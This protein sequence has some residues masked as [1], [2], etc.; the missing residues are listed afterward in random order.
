MKTITLN[1]TLLLYL[2]CLGFT[3]TVVSQTQKEAS[4]KVSSG[5]ILD[6][7]IRQ[8]NVNIATSSGTEVKVLAKNIEEDELKL[9]TMEQKS[10]KLEIKFKGEDSDE[11][12]LNLTIPSEINLDISTGGGNIS[13]KGDLKGTVDA[14]TG[15]G[16]IS[17]GNIFGKTELSTA[18]GNISV[19][20]VNGDAELSTAG[21]DMKAGTISGKAELST[22]GGNITVGSINNSAELSTAGGNINVK[23]IGGNADLS[24]AGG[25]VTV[26][27]V[28]GSAEL[29]TAGGNIILESANGKVEAS[30]AAGNINLK[31]IEGSIEASTAAGNIYAELHPEGNST[32][33]L[34]SAVG[35][36]TL[37][38]PGNAKVTIIATLS[39]NAWGSSDD[40]LDHIKSD[41]AETEVNK[42]G[43]KRQIEVIYKLNGGGPIIGL[44]AAMGE[45]EIR[46]LN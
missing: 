8:G 45:I 27:N 46:K 20:D 4:F 33:E 9:L 41:F 25:N 11:F 22:A 36:V 7:S 2:F 21:G 16:D 14:S 18:G 43:D 29:S 38:I 44:N 35:N 24:T 26:G 19:G 37:K 15:G 6:V 5:E 28:S 34:N 42:R 40:A 17:A 10:G 31:N 32:S 12:E 13:V 30:T 1:F 39:I 3:I 23:D